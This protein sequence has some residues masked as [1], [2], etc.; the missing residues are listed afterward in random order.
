MGVFLLEKIRFSLDLYD[1]VPSARFETQK[2]IEK[3]H[4]FF[5]TL[6]RQGILRASCS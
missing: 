6:I 4:A 2:E 3:W 1:K 5:G